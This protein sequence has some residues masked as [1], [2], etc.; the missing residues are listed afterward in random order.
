MQISFKQKKQSFEINMKTNSRRIFLCRQNMGHSNE[1]TPHFLLSSKI[2]PAV[3]LLKR[4]KKKKPQREKLNNHF[5]LSSNQRTIS[6][7]HSSCRSSRW[8]TTSNDC[9]KS[10]SNRSPNSTISSRKCRKQPH[11]RPA[12]IKCCST[13]M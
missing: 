5:H 6:S 13:I 2:P 10:S 8:N 1:T 12:T 3:H 9:T 4:K 7:R 11:Q